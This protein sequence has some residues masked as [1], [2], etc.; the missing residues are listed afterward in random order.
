MKKIKVF[1]GDTRLKDVWVGASKWEVFKFRTARFLRKL[2]ITTAIVTSVSGIAYGS[3][4][5]GSTLS[6]VTVFA[7]RVVNVPVTPISPVL[8][9]IEKCESS[10]MQDNTQGQ[11]LIH[12]NTNGTYD[13]GEYQINSTWN[14]TA[15]KLGY[16]LSTSVGNE[17]MAQWLYEN[18]GTSP[19]SSSQKCWSK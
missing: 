13:Q 4:K 8:S 3:F 1:A 18:V 12:V 9:R 7:D 14:A 19:W 10:D 5:A 15:T 6:P 11:M 17:S 2:F 16:D